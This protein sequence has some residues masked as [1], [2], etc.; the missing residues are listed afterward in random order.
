MTTSRELRLNSI[1]RHLVASALGFA[2]ASLCLGCSSQPARPSVDISPRSIDTILGDDLKQAEA[3][4]NDPILIIG[5]T[6]GSPDTVGGVDVS[7]AAINRSSK[8][9]KYL[10]WTLVAYNR[11]D[12]PV[13]CRIRRSS[14]ADL[15]LTGP[16]APGEPKLEGRPTSA[17]H[18]EWMLHGWSWG[19]VWYNATVERAVV[20]QVE[21]TFM[22]NTKIV[23]AHPTTVAT[24]LRFLIY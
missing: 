16:V 22:D 24:K 1:F 4:S 13:E 14:E 10:D 20:K 19:K 12:D 23:I 8:P 9:I 3:T 15:R 18:D 5:V 6:T 11:V 2:L 7:I 21:V 17:A